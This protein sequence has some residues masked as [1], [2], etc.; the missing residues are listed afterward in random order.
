MVLDPNV[1]TSP[2]T[3]TSAVRTTPAD[4]HNYQLTTI[5]GLADSHFYPVIV[6][7]NVA[8][9]YLHNNVLRY[10]HE[11]IVQIDSGVSRL[12][13]ASL[14]ASPRSSPGVSPPSRR[15]H[16]PIQPAS[17]W[18]P[19]AAATSTQSRALVWKTQR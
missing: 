5:G 8:A 18:Q 19:M 15:I 13:P 7:G 16:A 12:Q 11:Y 14:R 3:T 4:L 1:P 10:G 6:H 9:I 2:T 17:S